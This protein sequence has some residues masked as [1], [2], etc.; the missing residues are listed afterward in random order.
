MLLKPCPS[1]LKKINNNN[2]SDYKFND[3]QKIKVCIGA[4]VFYKECNNN[5]YVVGILSSELKLE[6]I[7]QDNM[8]LLLQTV[9]KGKD[10]KKKDETKIEEDT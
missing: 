9:I 3:K 4:P 7:N 10:C 2:Y 6:S 5:S 8:K 1:L